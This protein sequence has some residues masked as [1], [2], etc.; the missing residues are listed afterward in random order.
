MTLTIGVWV[1]MAFAVWYVPFQLKCLLGLK[2][3][4]PLAFV[5]AAVLGSYMLV[6]YRGSTPMTMPRWP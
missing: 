3:A 4:W 6:L 5:S 2:L 1:L